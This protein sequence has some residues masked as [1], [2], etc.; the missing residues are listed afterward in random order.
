LEDG[1]VGS[2]VARHRRD[3]G[4]VPRVTIDEGLARWRWHTGVESR[5]LEPLPRA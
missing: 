2:N 3:F 4:Y 1:R 5:R